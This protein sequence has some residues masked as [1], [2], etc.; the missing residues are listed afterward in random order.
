MSS[1]ARRAPKATNAD[2][3]P[4]QWDVFDRLWDEKYRSLLHSILDDGKDYHKW[5]KIFRDALS[6]ALDFSTLGDW[7]AYKS[8]IASAKTKMKTAVSTAIGR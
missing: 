3:A 4:D 5:V 7:M 2:I 6:D 1:R 8:D